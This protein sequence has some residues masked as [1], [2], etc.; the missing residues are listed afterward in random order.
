MEYPLEICCGGLSNVLLVRTGITT[1]SMVG[2][3]VNRRERL[4]AKPS[5]ETGD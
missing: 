4:Y 3:H 1:E 2:S 5:I